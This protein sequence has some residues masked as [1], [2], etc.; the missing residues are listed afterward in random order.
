MFT[1]KYT[2]R[3]FSCHKSSNT[4]MTRDL[5]FSLK[6]QIHVQIGLHAGDSADV[7]LT[8]WII[9]RTRFNHKSKYGGQDGSFRDASVGHHAFG[10]LNES[11]TCPVLVWLQA[12]PYGLPLLDC[13]LLPLYQICVRREVRKRC[14]EMT[15]KPWLKMKLQFPFK[16]WFKEKLP[17][18]DI[19]NTDPLLSEFSNNTISVF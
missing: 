6:V 17:I 7:Y 13:L 18:M 16:R 5:F 10:L 19:S 2:C 9:L 12:L 3:N 1:W 4:E 11:I 8:R 14:P 15:R